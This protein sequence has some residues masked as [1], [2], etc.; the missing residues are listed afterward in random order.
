MNKRIVVH[1]LLILG[2][3]GTPTAQAGLLSDCTHVP[4]YQNVPQVCYYPC[5]TVYKAGEESKDLQVHLRG[6]S[7]NVLEIF[8]NENVGRYAIPNSLNICTHGRVL[9]PQKND[10]GTFAVQYGWA[11]FTAFGWKGDQMVTLTTGRNE[12]PPTESDPNPHAVQ[13]DIDPRYPIQVE[14]V[15]TRIL[16]IVHGPNCGLEY[17][18]RFDGDAKPWKLLYTG[19]VG[20]H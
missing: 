10:R 8:F 14:W 15:T 11:G 13:I 4:I 9:M 5:Y 2:C 18:V 17:L 12:Y 1:L 3:L 6:A 7:Y 19:P 16:R 20:T